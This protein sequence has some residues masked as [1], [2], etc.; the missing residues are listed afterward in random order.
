VH[1]IDGMYRAANRGTDIGGW[2]V[3][4]FSPGKAVLEKT[5]PHHCVLEEGILEA[6]LRA[7]NVTA[8]IYQRTCFRKGADSCEIVISSHIVDGRWTGRSGEPEPVSSVLSPPTSR[9]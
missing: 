1:G 8:T 9:R 7:V 3:L 5:T 4:D 6:A 2:A